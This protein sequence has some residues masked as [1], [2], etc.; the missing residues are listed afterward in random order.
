M[1]EAG[2]NE[3]PEAE[4]LDALDIAHDEIKK[5]CAAQR[6]LA[7]KAGKAKIEVEVPQVDPELYEQIKGS[8]GAALDA[9]TQVEDKLERQDAT[10]RRSRS[11]SSSSTRATPRPRPTPSTAP[12][13]SAPSTS[14]RRR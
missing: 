13:P 12:T 8:H 1:V 5:L 11:R 4:I 14:S 6:E 3:I 9:A 7:E 2:A 10:A